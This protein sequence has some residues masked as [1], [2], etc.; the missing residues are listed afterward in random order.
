MAGN[1]D[2]QVSL[3]LPMSRSESQGLTCPSRADLK[4]AVTLASSPY[5]PFVRSH[6][7][8]P[9]TLLPPGVPNRMSQQLSS[10]LQPL[11][12]SHEII[13]TLSSLATL[14]SAVEMARNSSNDVAFDP[15]GF[16]EEWMAITHALLS[17]PGPLRETDSHPDAHNPYC[18]ET[19]TL[20]SP[21]ASGSHTDY[22]MANHRL[23]PFI[24]IIP[25]PSPGLVG[26]LEPALRIAGLLFLKELLP[27]WPR[28][29]GGYA[30]LLS[31]LRDHL[32]EILR[33]CREDIPP[34]KNRLEVR[35]QPGAS[36]TTST[37]QPPARISSSQ[38]QPLIRSTPPPQP[39]FNPNPNRN[40]YTN[41]NPQNLKPIL[42][43]LS[44]IGD[45]VSRLGNT[46][47]SRQVAD[48]YYPREIFR[49]CL[50]GICGLVDRASIDTLGD[51]DLVIL[52]LFDLRMIM[53]EGGRRG[54]DG[55]GGKQGEEGWDM[56]EV[57][58]EVIRGV[59]GDGS[60]VGG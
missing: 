10:L 7:D 50:W 56:R 37:K 18:T 21:S 38:R 39:T 58:R 15:H 44:L 29:L 26:P 34:K 25:A 49:E 20:D 27:D 57:I 16:T 54:E 13:T 17:R 60:G 12:I 2:L 52:R 8:S 32:L 6:N 19:N 53:S 31:L 22:Y 35:S 47:E 45:T 33:R 46:N 28:N 1:R 11:G 3:G 51:E 59:L 5:L 48:E 55:Q 24:P 30:V 42:L 4:G 43:F 14:T 36:G 40:P 9:P 41:S 23:Q